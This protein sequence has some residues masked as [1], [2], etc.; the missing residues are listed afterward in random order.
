M[1]YEGT[2]YDDDGLGNWAYR[3]RYVIIPQTEKTLCSVLAHLSSSPGLEDVSHLPAFLHLV[4]HRV[5]MVTHELL[6]SPN[7]GHIRLEATKVYARSKSQA[8]N[9]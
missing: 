6:I 7:L 3:Y 8:H 1:E 5:A 9:R 4:V 2:M